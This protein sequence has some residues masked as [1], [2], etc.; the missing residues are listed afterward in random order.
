MKSALLKI[1]TAILL[2]SAAP[3]GAETVPDLSSCKALQS[4]SAYGK[5]YNDHM[6]LVQGKDGWIFRT[7]QDFRTEFKV[8]TDDVTT[9]RKL[10]DALK[11]KGTV[12]VVAYPPTRGMAAADKLPSDNSLAKGYDPATATRNYTTYIQAMSAA[13][14]H[15]VG[16]PNPR[17]GADYFYKADQHWTTEGAAEMA[18]AVGAAIK[19]LPVYQTVRKTEFA[20]TP[21]A[22][23]TFEGKFSA[24]IKDICNQKMPDEKAN[25]TQT[26]PKGT[27]SDDASLFGDMPDP[28]IVLVGTSNSN[29]DELDMNFVGSLKQ[30]LSADVYNAAISGGGLD[31]SILAYLSSESFKKNPAKILIWEIPGYYDLGGEDAGKTLQQAIPAVYGDCQTAIAES[32]PLTLD[33]DDIELFKNLE[34][35][36]IHAGEFYI[37]LSLDK[38]VKKKFPITF[39][40]ADGDK[41]IVR[42]TSSR[43]PDNRSFFYALGGKNMSPIR[44]ISLEP[45]KEMDGHTASARLCKL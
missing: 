38:P 11:K 10:S 12:L 32:G 22:G 7:E 33:G 15:I 34:S 19:A 18:Q 4:E 8:N 30:A 3:A 27:G 39:V 36:Q 28:D 25:V 9:F 20:T 21:G 24:A 13:G 42:F 16:T 40:K 31:D 5:K 26:A 45:T 37:Y 44:S 23:G 29:R 1:L 6:Y 17:I 14:I 43:N 2:F 41:K 35:K